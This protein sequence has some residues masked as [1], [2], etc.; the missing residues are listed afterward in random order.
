MAIGDGTNQ[1]EARLSEPQKCLH[2]ISCCYSAEECPVCEVDR[3]RAELEEAKQYIVWHREAI[4]EG[5]AH[6]R[7][8]DRLRAENERLIG[9]I[10]GVAKGGWIDLNWVDSLPNKSAP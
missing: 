1:R 5:L 6:L 8:A 4:A 9:V 3:L 10:K 2:M 7:E